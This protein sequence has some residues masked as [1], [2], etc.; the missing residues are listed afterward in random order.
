MPKDNFGTGL[1]TYLSGP[2]TNAEQEQVD[3]I[4]ARYE[5]KS[6]LRIVEKQAID[7]VIRDRGINELVC[8]GG[9]DFF[10]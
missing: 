8:H 1:G 6:S 9:L 2:L 4:I 5:G 3:R 10:V 7:N